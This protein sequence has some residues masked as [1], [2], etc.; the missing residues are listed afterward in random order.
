[1]ADFR[2]ISAAGKTIERVLN[3]CFEEEQPISDQRPTRAVLV[4]SQDFDRPNENATTIPGRR[5][6]SSST[7]SR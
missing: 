4:R 3:A 1:M 6:R 7:A 2:C 5:C